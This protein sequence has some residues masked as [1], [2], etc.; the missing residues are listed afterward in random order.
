MSRTSDAWS[1]L[2]AEMRAVDANRNTQSWI[3]YA[4]KLEA[5]VNSLRKELDD[6]V[7]ANACN[8]AEKVVLRQE[9]MKVNPEHPL[10]AD[11]VR[12]TKENLE[13]GK[14]MRNLIHENASK[15]MN[16]TNNYD[17]VRDWA[18]RVKF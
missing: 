9:L 11:Y 7:D 1:T 16:A 14:F 17:S 4:N 6:T 2:F 12:P 18:K 8:I 5:R 15:V 3:D 13:R 10:I